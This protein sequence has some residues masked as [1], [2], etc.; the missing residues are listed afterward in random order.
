MMLDIFLVIENSP[1]LATMHRGIIDVFISR[2]MH[3]LVLGY[4]ARKS[5]NQ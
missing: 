2:L 4:D 1:T 3:D 5:N